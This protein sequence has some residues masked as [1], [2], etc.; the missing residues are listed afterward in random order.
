MQP[1][2]LLV[3]IRWYSRVTVAASPQTGRAYLDDASCGARLRPPRRRLPPRDRG[4]GEHRSRRSGTRST[5]ATATSRPTSTRPATASC[6]PSTTPSSTG[7]PTGPARSPDVDVRRGAA[8]AR[9][10]AGSR[11]RRWPSSSTRSPT[12]ASTSTSSRTGRSRPLADFIE[13][14]RGLGPGA[15]RL[16]LRRPGCSAFR[17]LTSGRV[18]T[19]PHPLEVAAFV[20]SPS[21]RLADRLTRGRPA[22]LQIP[23]RRGPLTVATR[24]SRAARARGRQARARVDHRRPGRDAR[25]ARSWRRRADDRPHRHTQG[26]APRA[27]PVE[28]TG[29]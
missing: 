21:A 15:G 29:R 14:R 6:S 3:A 17:R 13:E 10:A 1:T 8:R 11:C 19:R 18:A 28:G 27:R 9:S 7:S 5:S 16:V 23:H 22:A 20:L 24:R 12:P 4:P 25:A 26:R 2:V